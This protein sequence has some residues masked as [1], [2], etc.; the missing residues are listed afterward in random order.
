MSQPSCPN[1][2]QFSMH[3]EVRM[4]R[5]FYLLFSYLENFSVD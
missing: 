3:A 1:K 2:V 4:K 5:M